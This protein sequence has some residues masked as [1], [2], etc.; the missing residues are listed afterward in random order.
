MDNPIIKRIIGLKEK[1]NRD[2]EGAYLIDGA[3][4]CMEALKLGKDVDLLIISQG[5]AEQNIEIIEYAEQ[6]DIKTISVPESIFKKIADVKTPVGVA[7]VVKKDH[8]SEEEFFAG[9]SGNYLVLDRIRD[10]GNAGTLIRT[11]EAAGFKGV[12]VMKGTVDVYGPKTV[13]AAAGSLLRQAIYQVESPDELIELCEK[14][15]KQIA[16]TIPK[17]GVPFY[18]IGNK[19]N[20]ALVIGNEGDGVQKRLIDNAEML[21]E[22]PMSGQVESLNAAVAGGILMYWFGKENTN[23]G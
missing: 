9:K 13:R 20:L 21:V 22:I 10:P 1:K 8:I 2:R 5:Q 16:V 3:H 7:A 4:V 14:R 23:N 19:Q 15:R 18:D 6:T 12:I 17:G 11:S